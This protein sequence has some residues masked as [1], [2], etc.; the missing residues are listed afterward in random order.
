MCAGICFFFIFV[1]YRFVQVKNQN[2]IR[3]YNFCNRAGGKISGKKNPAADL[4]ALEAEIDL[5][6]EPIAKVFPEPTPA[7]RRRSR[8]MADKSATPPLEGN[9]TKRRHGH[10]IE[11]IQP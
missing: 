8:A 3:T 6:V 10:Q 2:H 7:F 5:M 4:S 1:S 11:G 9:L